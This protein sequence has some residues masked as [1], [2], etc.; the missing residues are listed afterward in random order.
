MGLVRGNGSM[1]QGAKMVY[2]GVKGAIGA[3]QTARK[4]LSLA[5]W[6]AGLIN[7]EKKFYDVNSFVTTTNFNSTGSVGI[8]TAMAEGSDYNQRNGN[9]IL[10]TSFLVN[11]VCSSQLAKPT[12]C[13]VIVFIDREGNTGT[14]PTVGDVLESAVTESPLQHDTHGRFQ[15]LKDWKFCLNDGN[16]PN[17]YLKTYIKLNTNRHKY[18]NQRRHHIKFTGTGAGV[19][20]AD[21]GHIYV[22]FLSDSATADAPS[23]RIYTRLRYID[24]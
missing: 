8:Y 16:G 13:R 7:V 14:I 5:K 17:K 18:M 23:G 2:K 22:L 4:A 19:A 11:I 6:V 24:N 10:A 1:A 15:V 3:A 12:N 21:E 20:N 9:S